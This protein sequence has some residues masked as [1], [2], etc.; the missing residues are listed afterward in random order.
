[1]KNKKRYKLILGL[2]WLVFIIWEIIVMNWANKQE[3]IIV[4][5]DLII[6]LPVL[7]LFTIYILFQIY[8]DKQKN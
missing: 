7:I 8:R 3:N 6:I 2:C 4:R 5:I 1:M